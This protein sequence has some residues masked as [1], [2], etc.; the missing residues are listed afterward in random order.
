MG[1]LFPEA[2]ISGLRVE[3]TSAGSRLPL[4]STLKQLQHV[5]Y[6]DHE[7]DYN[8]IPFSH[9]PG[10]SN[11]RQYRDCWMRQFVGL[12]GYRLPKSSSPPSL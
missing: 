6:H 9:G 4:Q 8:R 2:S 7:I 10:L 5:R 3:D 12:M 1:A 11:S